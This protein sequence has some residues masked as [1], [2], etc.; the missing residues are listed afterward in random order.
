MNFES[1]GPEKRVSFTVVASASLHAAMLALLVWKG[2]VFT[3]AG[4]VSGPVDFIDGAPIARP[5]LARPNVPK[6]PR[7]VV[8]PLE[9]TGVVTSEAAEAQASPS[10]ATTSA[11]A[12]SS[13][14]SNVA[15]G[16]DSSEMARYV[17]LLVSALQKNRRYPREAIEREEEGVVG[18][19]VKLGSNGDLIE[20]AVKLASPFSSLNEA[21]LKT[22]QTIKHFPKPPI[23]DGTV[24][25]LAIPM[26][27]K[28]ERL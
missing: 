8:A 5:E 13:G 9:A 2:G 23:A 24:I 28:I 6:K 14:P 12:A 27:F 18:L 17:G 3:P 4:S 11:D 7:V 21:A 20:A 10:S 25:E 22:V 1:F 19:T 16:R 26:R 15:A